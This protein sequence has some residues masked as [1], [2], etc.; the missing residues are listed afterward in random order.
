MTEHNHFKPGIW[1]SLHRNNCIEKNEH[2]EV[3]KIEQL[4][5]RAEWA[6]IEEW[7]KVKEDIVIDW[8]RCDLFPNKNARNTLFLMEWQF[9][10]WRNVESWIHF[11]T[12][13]KFAL[14]ITKYAWNRME[15]YLATF[16]DSHSVSLRFAPTLCICWEPLPPYHFFWGK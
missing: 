1:L 4:L 6:F 9:G 5:P 3:H 12:S 10:I 14:Q 15:F 8:V 11:F 7:F 2:K 13:S 16:K